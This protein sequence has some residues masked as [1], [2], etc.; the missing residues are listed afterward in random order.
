MPTSKLKLKLSKINTRWLEY[1][2]LSYREPL[3]PCLNVSGPFALTNAGPGKLSRMDLFSRTRYFRASPFGKQLGWL[4]YRTTKFLPNWKQL[5]SANCTESFS[6]RLTKL[7]KKTSLNH[8]FGSSVSEDSIT[9][10][11]NLTKIKVH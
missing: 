9:T 6:H 2:Y 11:Q 10:L 7:L 3:I 8:V 5:S 1:A 4:I